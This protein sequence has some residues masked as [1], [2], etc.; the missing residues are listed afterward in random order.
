MSFN[1]IFFIY[2]HPRAQPQKFL[3]AFASLFKGLLRNG[4][5]LPVK[6]R[7]YQHVQRYQRSFSSKTCKK[8]PKMS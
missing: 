5:K 3:S 2:G 6:I 7:F 8:F 1:F 4:K